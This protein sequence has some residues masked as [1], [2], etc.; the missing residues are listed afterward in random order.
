MD[1]GL[2]GKEQ[3][4]ELASRFIR[5]TERVAREDNA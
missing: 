5:E 3:V 4:E 2:S 1:M